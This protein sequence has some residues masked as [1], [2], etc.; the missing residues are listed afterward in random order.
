[1]DNFDNAEWIRWQW[2]EMSRKKCVSQIQEVKK[3]GRPGKMRP[4][5][6]LG[7]RAHNKAK[8][9]LL[10]LQNA[11][12]MVVICRVS[13]SN[14]IVLSPN[15][16]Q[17]ADTDVSHW[18]ELTH[19]INQNGS[20]QEPYTL[21]SKF[22]CTLEKNELDGENMGLYTNRQMITDPMYGQNLYNCCLSNGFNLKLGH[23]LKIF[24][25]ETNR[26]A[27]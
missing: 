9:N 14:D 3:R 12:L 5:T 1:L 18:E 13:N 21:T 17:V 10:E 7:E 11:T 20:P 8:S 19:C 4:A 25:V 15:Q 22:K 24:F 6:D 23:N 26:P 16:F 2:V 27:G